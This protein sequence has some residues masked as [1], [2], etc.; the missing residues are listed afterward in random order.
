MSPVQPARHTH[1]NPA[2]PPPSLVRANG[3]L[4]LPADGRLTRGEDTE[5]QLSAKAVIFLD[6]DGVLLDDVHFLTRLEQMRVLDGVAQGIRLL[7]EQFCVVV[8]S[9][10]SGIAR[11]LLTEE[12][13]LALHSAMLSRL[14]DQGA[15]VDAIYYCPHLAG[16]RIAAYD[17]ECD[18][19]KPKPG[20]LLRA[21]QDWGFDL[22]RSYMIGDMP[23]DIE[24]GAAAG[25]TCVI[26]GESEAPPNTPAFPAPDLPAAADLILAHRRGQS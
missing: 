17:I 12:E 22:S 19:R 26:L 21:Q 9:N 5:G 20:M 11:G 25:V 18:C 2:Q 24:A 23:R 14:L 15:L 4:H 3:H 16:A 7:Q 1:E 13:L 10:Q 8:V 6:R